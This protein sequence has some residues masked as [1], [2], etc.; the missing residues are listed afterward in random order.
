MLWQ[1]PM[2]PPSPPF[3]A[4]VVVLVLLL[5]GCRTA[6]AEQTG[7]PIPQ[8]DVEALL[9]DQRQ[10]WNRGDWDGFIAGYWDD[11]GLTFNGAGGITRGRSDLLANY[12]KN[13]PDAAARGRL[14][15][16]LLEFRPVGNNAALVLGRYELDRAEPA[17]GYFS[18]LVERTPQGVK[19]IHDHTS[20][21]PKK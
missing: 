11:A 3:L 16:H 19:I 9:E 17:S 21:S 6:T 5:A 8:K 15:F 14:T 1:T 18:L 12:Q 4:C 2:K 10:A 20:A 7:P 13:Y